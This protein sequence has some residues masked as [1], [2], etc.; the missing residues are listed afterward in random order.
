LRTYPFKV[1]YK[2]IYSLFKASGILS[3]LVFKIGAT[4]FS[5]DTVYLWLYG[6]DEN[7]KNSNVQKLIKVIKNEPQTQE[8]II[9]QLS[10]LLNNPEIQEDLSSGFKAMDPKEFEQL[11][12]PNKKQ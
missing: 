8:E 3:K 4:Y 12:N 2:I 6:N 10:V 11:I 7:R 5:A 9:N 1:T